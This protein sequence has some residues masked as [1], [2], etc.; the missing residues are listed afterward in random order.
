MSYLNGLLFSPTFFNLSLN[1]AKRSSWYEPLSA[2]GLVFVD[3]IELPHLQLQKNIINWILVMTIWWCPCVKLSLDLL[4]RTFVM[5]RCF[6]GKTLLVFVL[7]YF[8]LQGQTCL[9]LQVSL[10]FL[11]LHSSPLWWKG[12][13]VLVLVPEGLLGLHRTINFSFFSISLWG[14]DLNYSA[15]DICLGN[16]PRL[17]CHFWDCTKFCILDSFLDYEGYSTSSKVFLPTV[18]DM[19]FWMKFACTHTF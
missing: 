4:E 11:L 10:D 18:V 8:V 16:E 13:L 19:A 7:L 6:L 5:T 17:F 3:C 1:F 15:I 9:L 2:P 14:I 12:H